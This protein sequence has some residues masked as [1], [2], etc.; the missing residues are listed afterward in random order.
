MEKNLEQKEEEELIIGGDFNVKIG[1]ERKLYS[2]EPEEERKKRNSKDSI[3]NEER[4][5]C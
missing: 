5:K 4:K 2:G 1:R 3:I